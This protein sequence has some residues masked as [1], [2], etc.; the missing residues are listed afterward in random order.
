[1]YV[2]RVCMYV[3]G[4][5]PPLRRPRGGNLYCTRFFMNSGNTGLTDMSSEPKKRIHILDIGNAV[6]AAE[7]GPCGYRTCQY[8]QPPLLNQ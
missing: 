2:C 6:F 8:L 1:M 5:C 7:C 3:P 4:E